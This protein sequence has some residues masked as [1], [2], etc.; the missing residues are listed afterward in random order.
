VRTTARRKNERPIHH[1]RFVS[2][3]GPRLFH[4]LTLVLSRVSETPMAQWGQSFLFT[5]PSA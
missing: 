4:F 3:S 5:P 2:R 1:C